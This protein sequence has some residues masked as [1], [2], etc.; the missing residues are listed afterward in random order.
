MVL[1]LERYPDSEGGELPTDAEIPLYLSLKNDEESRYKIWD[2]D[3]PQ[4]FLETKGGFADIKDF[5]SHIQK[6]N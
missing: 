1:K 4:E 5:I 6:E 2:N 3:Y